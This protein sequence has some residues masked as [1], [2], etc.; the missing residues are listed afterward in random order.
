MIKIAYKKSYS[1][2]L[3][4]VEFEIP[5]QGISVIF[6]SSGSGKTSLLNLIAGLNEKSSIDDY[7]RFQ[8]KQDIYDDSANGINRKPWQRNI[9]YVF[10]DNR[11][12]PNMTVEENIL[13]GYERRKSQADPQSIIEK[14]KLAELLQQYPSQLSGGQKQRVAMARALLSN[15]EILILDEPL[16]ALDYQARQE[17]IPFIDKIQR[18]LTIPILYVSHDIKEVL[19]LANY[20]VILDQGKVVDQGDIAELCIN[21]PLLTQAEGASFIVEGIVH[22]L[23][24]EDKLAKVQ[25]DKTQL[26]I[27]GQNMQPG[28]QV[29]IL[30][31]ARDVSLCLSPPRDSSILNCIAVTIDSIKEDSNGKLLVIAVMGTQRIAAM[32]SHRSARLLKVQPGKEMFAQFKATAMIK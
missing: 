14:F 18:E 31:H 7:A 15:P 11:L 21:Q 32:I 25:C 9:G 29:R 22:Q 28:K 27:T 30:I 13:F 10:Q 6:G 12:F 23:I 20:I 19:R 4:D 26:L 3:L 2:F 17:L 24:G 5:E 16:S 1:N 8:L